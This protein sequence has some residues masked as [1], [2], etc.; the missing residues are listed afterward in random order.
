VFGW[1]YSNT[2]SDR[3]TGFQR[4]AD[5]HSDCDIDP[6]AYCDGDAFAHD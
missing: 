6:H 1:I 5:G 3:N 2:D 4:D